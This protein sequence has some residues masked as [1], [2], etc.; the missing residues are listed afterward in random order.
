M[1]VI[2]SLVAAIGLLRNNVTLIIG[3]MVIAPLLGPNVALAFS[4]TLADYQMAKASLKTLL[5]GILVALSV[6]VLIGF[7]FTVDPT[8]SEIHSRTVVSYADLVLALAA[9]IAGVLSY[10]SGLSTTLIGVMVAVALL[11][12]LAAFGLLLGS[13]RIT[14]ALN[15]MLLFFINLI[16]VNLSGVI[17]LVISGIKPRAWWEAKKARRLTRIAIAFWT[18]LILL[19]AALIFIQKTAVQK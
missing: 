3:A 4:T 9:G 19:L 5:T 17:T 15:A 6:T 18:F 12:P 2:S 11:P 14:L 13:G 10:T 7:L 1:I 16:C 8:L